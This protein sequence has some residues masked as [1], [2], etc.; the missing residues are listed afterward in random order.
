LPSEI[1]QGNKE[2]LYLMLNY[3]DIKFEKEREFLQEQKKNLS[4]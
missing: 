1:I 2:D 4:K 3:F